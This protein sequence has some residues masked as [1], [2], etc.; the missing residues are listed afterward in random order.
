MEFASDQSCAMALLRGKQK[1]DYYL[2]HYDGIP[3]PLDFV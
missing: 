3:E 2:Q 1:L